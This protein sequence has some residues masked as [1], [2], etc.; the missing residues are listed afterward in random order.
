MYFGSPG[1]PEVFFALTLGNLPDSWG[2]Y[3]D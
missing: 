2:R 1:L 3:L